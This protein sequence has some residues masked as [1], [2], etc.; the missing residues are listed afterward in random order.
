MNRATVNICVQVLCG[1]KCSN[2][3][4]KYRGEQWYEYIEFCEKQLNDHLNELYHFALP[5]AVYESFCCST[6]SQAFDV[7]SASDF[8][9]SRQH[10]KKQRHYFANIGPSSQSYGFFSSHVWM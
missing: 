3:F 2:P 7:F 8:G 10:V 9:S 5:P 6:S 4:H 1:C